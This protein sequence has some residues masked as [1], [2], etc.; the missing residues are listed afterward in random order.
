MEKVQ[1]Q[2]YKLGVYV[3]QACIPVFYSILSSSMPVSKIDLQGVRK[4]EAR[5]VW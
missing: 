1:N 2:E 5:E 3:L 4:E